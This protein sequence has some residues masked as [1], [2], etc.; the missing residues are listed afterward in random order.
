[1]S[2]ADGLLHERQAKEAAAAAQKKKEFEAVKRDI[3]RG[4]R[5]WFAAV[6]GG[7]IEVGF[8]GYVLSIG[9]DSWYVLDT[10]D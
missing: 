9:Q 3:E 6:N 4:M 10:A 1:M 8:H 2:M 5:P 7:R